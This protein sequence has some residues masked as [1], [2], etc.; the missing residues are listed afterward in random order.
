MHRRVAIHATP[1]K[2]AAAREEQVAARGV[3][4]LRGVTRLVVTLLAESRDARVE[5]SAMQGA[6]GVVAGRAALTHGQVLPQYRRALLGVAFLAIVLFAIWHTRERM[7]WIQTLLALGALTVFALIFWR[8]W[9]IVAMVA[10]I[11]ALAAL[12]TRRTRPAES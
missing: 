3:V 4:G 2:Q 1:T 10:A 8:G 6:V 5:H 9:L 7:S 12:A 11:A